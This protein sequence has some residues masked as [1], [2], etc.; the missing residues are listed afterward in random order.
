MVVKTGG[1][2]PCGVRY[3]SAYQA[4][5]P[6]WVTNLGHPVL[7]VCEICY[8]HDFPVL[9]KFKNKPIFNSVLVSIIFES[10]IDILGNI[11]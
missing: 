5:I 11:K 2:S 6:V 1:F 10:K 9:V 7:T 4:V 8:L 3:I